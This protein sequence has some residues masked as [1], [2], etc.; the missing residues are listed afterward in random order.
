MGRRATRS[1]R[2][3]AVLAAGAL[4]MTLTAAAPAGAVTILLDVVSAQSAISSGA[5]SQPLQGALTL[6]VGTLPAGPGNTSF[7]VVGL[8]LD[9][10]PALGAVGLDPSASHPGLGVLAADGRFLIPTLFLR[11][12]GAGGFALAIPDV[13]G[14][15]DFG[16]GG[17]SIASLSAQFEIDAGEEG[18]LSVTLVAVPEPA[19]LA[20]GV[21]GLAALGIARRR[22]EVAPR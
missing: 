17:A 12:G 10:A 22:R 16:A 4:G 18:L 8:A 3:A 14:R 2:I 13:E 19:S 15:V 6:E 11:I 1:T 21:L 5:G 9:A 20:L 7:D